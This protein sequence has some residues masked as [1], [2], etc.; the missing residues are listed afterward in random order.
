M[1]S[2]T[3]SGQKRPKEL[4]QTWI[5]E[6]LQSNK[7]RIIF[8]KAAEK[9][10]RSK[11]KSDK[12][13]LTF[14]QGIKQYADRILFLPPVK[15]EKQGR[16]LL[17]VSRETL[18]RT[19][20]LAMVYRIEQDPKYL[21]RLEETL[22]TVCNFSDWN[23]D[24]FLDVAEMAVALSLPLDWLADELSPSTKKMIHKALVD[25]AFKPSIGINRQRT[26][27]WNSE[28]NWNLVC[29][30]GLAVAALAIY[31][32]EPDLA[33]HILNRSYQQLPL[34][35]KPYY[36]DGAYNEG[37]SYW[38][39]ATNYLTLTLSAFESSLGTKF[40]FL[41]TK[42][43]I[44]SALFT[45]VT[46][47]P[48]GDYFNYFDASL[49]GYKSTSH[50]GLL[51]WFSNRTETN[52]LGNSS[53]ENLET[54]KVKFPIDRFTPL[55][56]ISLSQM[57]D[58]LPEVELPQAWLAGGDSPVGVFRPADEDGL[59]LA[60]KGGSAY[61]NHGNMDAGSFIIEWKKIRWA[62]DLGNQN[63]STLEET[64]GS[65]AL[66]GRGQDS[67]RWTLLTKNNFGHNTLSINDESHL[68][69]ARAL[70]SVSELEKSTPSFAFDLSPLFGKN[71]D[72]A[73]RTFQKVSDQKICIKDD[74]QVNENT[75][76]IRWQ[77][78]TTAKVDVQEGGVLLTQDGKS[79]FLKISSNQKHE[80]KVTSLDPPPLDYDKQIDQ[81]KRIDFIIK[82]VL[83]KG[84]RLHLSVD[85]IGK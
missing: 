28:H 19:L 22:V 71:V 46:A 60:A 4:S 6:H 77:L 2:I 84:S 50:I 47:G 83:S 20:S 14:Y 59:Y 79:L 58:D 85:I 27:W 18:K 16:R 34:G 32:E 48:S 40:D 42:G 3:A 15:R 45:E 36:P 82:P 35:L 44:E 10:F 78:L 31:E 75:K 57:S 26:W 8:T 23:P 9:Q 52:Y 72:S 7:P 43:V 24:H 76:F 64:I 53:E 11:L 74:I 1:F 66:W 70:V 68:V 39:Y 56:A 38:F 30:G 17:A 5:T 51:A 62:L 65:K 49:G 13:V 73:I 37:P 25:K 67:Q 54:R 21:Q 69:K 81:L 55:H 41:N 12:A 61:D 29:H 63:Y 80:T 33:S